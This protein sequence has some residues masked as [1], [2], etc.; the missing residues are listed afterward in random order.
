MGQTKSQLLKA[1]ARHTKTYKMGHYC[2]GVSGFASSPFQLSYNTEFKIKLVKLAL[3]RPSG[4][5][6]KPTCREFPEVQLRKWIRA[7]EASVL[8]SPLVGSAQAPA[9]TE[10]D[11]QDSDPSLAVASAQAPATTEP[12]VQDSDPSL[13]VA[14]PVLALPL[15]VPCGIIMQGSYAFAAASP[16]AASPPMLPA[17]TVPPTVR[18]TAISRERPVVAAAS[19]VAAVAVLAAPPVPV[20]LLEAPAPAE[21]EAAEDLLLLSR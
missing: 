16:A 17:L 6:I 7:F 5:R 19:P 13:A 14:V 8:A 3:S 11:V 20:M 9:T 4:Q 1:A 12:D 2:M 15:A 18:G 21:A 10:P